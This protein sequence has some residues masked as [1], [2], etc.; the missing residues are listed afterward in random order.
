MMRIT[1]FFFLISSVCVFSG[2]GTRETLA[3]VEFE[4]AKF[5]LEY[6]PDRSF[7]GYNEKYHPFFQP[8]GAAARKYLLNPD[9]GFQFGNFP[10]KASLLEGI[11]VVEVDTVARTY[12]KYDR[13]AAIT[14]LYVDPKLIDRPS[15]ETLR[16]FV[17]KAYSNPDSSNE[18]LKWLNHG[19]NVAA[20]DSLYVFETIY[21]LVYSDMASLEPQYQ[22]ADGKRI[23]KVGVDEQISF[24]DT[25]GE[26]PVWL[27]TGNLSDS[28]FYYWVGRKELVTEFGEYEA[29][30]K[31]FKDLYKDAKE[32]N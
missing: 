18:L 29:K 21:A 13:T 15:W 6:I 26:S 17:T 22:S 23:L 27:N 20:T 19:Y 28:T 16:K 5:G 8:S 3:E 11:D 2:C 32:R 10:K 14:T 1:I 30:G 12:E 25:S 7:E 31:K 4:K 9:D 24:K